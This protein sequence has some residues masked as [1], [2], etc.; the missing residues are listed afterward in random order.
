MD[1][2]L[3]R[4]V[5]VPVIA[6]G[7]PKVPPEQPVAASAKLTESSVLDEFVAD[8]YPESNLLPDDP[9]LRAEA[10][11]FIHTISTKFVPAWVVFFHSSRPPGDFLN[12]LEQVQ[13]LLHESGFVLEGY[14]IADIAVIPF[15][16]CTQVC[17]DSEIRAYPE[18]EGRGVLEAINSLS[19]T[20]L[21]KYWN[22]VY[23]HPN[24][25]TTFI[26]GFVKKEY[27]AVYGDLRTK[28]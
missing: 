12:A 26:K 28:K 15:L 22:N 13:A 2:S 27:K 23:T 8:L 11:F 7:R 10:R 25:K 1:P 20:R 16:A 9:F 21:Q 5:K 19:F 6:H 18:G 24:F 4:A 14:L 3:S 17:L